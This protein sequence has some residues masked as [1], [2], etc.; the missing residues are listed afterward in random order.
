MKT[1]ILRN[2]LAYFDFI[3]RYNKSVEIIS[4][5]L[6]KSGKIRLTYDIIR[7]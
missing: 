5:K 4:L 2:N 7:L 6:T 1:R 3:K